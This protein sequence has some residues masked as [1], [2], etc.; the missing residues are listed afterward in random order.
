MRWSLSVEL[1]RAIVS[2][3]RLTGVGGLHEHASAHEVPVSAEQ[4]TDLRRMGNPMSTRATARGF[5]V[6]GQRRPPSGEFGAGPSPLQIEGAWSP[7]LEAARRLFVE[8][9]RASLWV[10]VI[11]VR[12]EDVAPEQRLDGPGVLVVVRVAA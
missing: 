4:L 12:E 3:V 2:A 10:S 6:S 9:D 11:V 1:E 7:V 8:E 5:W